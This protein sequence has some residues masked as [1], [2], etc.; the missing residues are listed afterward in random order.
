[1]TDRLI[2][3]SLLDSTEK[4]LTHY[5]DNK[6]I[7]QGLGQHDLKRFK[8][9]IL[10]TTDMLVLHVSLTS[11]IGKL[12]EALFMCIFTRHCYFCCSYDRCWKSGSRVKVADWFIG[13]RIV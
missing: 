10:E 5:I 7:G 13:N 11:V 9:M 2:L 8:R 1:M 3:R 6:T 12:T 4:S